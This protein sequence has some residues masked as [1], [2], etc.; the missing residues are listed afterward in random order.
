MVECELWA[1]AKIILIERIGQKA[2]P[3]PAQELIQ[4]APTLPPL[5]TFVAPI[6]YRRLA[7]IDVCEILGFLTKPASSDDLRDKGLRSPKD[8]TLGP[9]SL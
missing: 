4:S 6:V 7:T 9:Q 5:G 3:W 2:Q 8:H 1:L